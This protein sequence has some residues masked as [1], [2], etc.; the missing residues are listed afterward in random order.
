MLQIKTI[1]LGS[2]QT[3]CYVAFLQNDGQKGTE[4]A[5][6]C[7]VIDPGNEPGFLLSYLKKQ[8]LKPLA[9]LLTHGHFDH[10]GAVDAVCEAYSVPLYAHEQEFAML[11]DSYTNLSELTGA[12]I[13]LTTQPIPLP[14]APLQI[15]DFT[16]SSIHTPGHTPGGACI[17]VNN[18]LFSGDTLFAGSVGRTDF[19]GGN[20]ATLVQSIETLFAKFPPNT[21]VYPGHG[22]S[23]TLQKEEQSNPYL[24]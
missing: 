19:P 10:I 21:T 5:N 9:V 16:I 13:Q 2:Y 4:G 17:L 24:G 22:D 7:L 23:T 1:P 18:V 12:A 3:N 15:Q 11:T 20:M 14:V 6:P 8:N